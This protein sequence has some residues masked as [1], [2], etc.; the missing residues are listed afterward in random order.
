MQLAA[1]FGLTLIIHAVNTSA[2]AARMAGVRTGR[3]VLAASLFNVLALGS[4][5]ANAFAG[6]LIASLTDQAAANRDMDALLF[7]YRIMLAAATVG[8]LLAGLLIPSLSRVLAAG[9]A[10]YE[11]RQSL[12]RVI[13]RSM[14]IRGSRR[15]RH[16]LV[17]PRLG[18]VR[19][20]RR[21]PFPKRFLIASVLVTSVYT[22]SQFAALYASAWVPEG[23]RTAVSLAPLLTGGGVLLTILLIDPVAALVT[24]Q[25]LRGQRP[26]QD[27]T[28]VTI[29]QVG[30]RLVGTLLAQVILWPAGWVLATITHWLVS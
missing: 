3:L 6:P 12:P 27:V 16:E 11:E 13:V 9:V 18:T 28:Y 4:R 21:T 7:D 10:S 17:A 29:W 19:E 23:A 2:Y 20:S 5:G 8:T 15:M 22:V 25:A 1:V 24:D 30:A 26:L 14:S